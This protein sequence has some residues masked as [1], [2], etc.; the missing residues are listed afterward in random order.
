MFDFKINVWRALDVLFFFFLSIHLGYFQKSGVAFTAWLCD[1]DFV[2]V[3]CILPFS[4]WQSVCVWAWVRATGRIG[5]KLSVDLSQ[6]MIS[7]SLCLFPCCRHTMPFQTWRKIWKPSA[8]PSSANSRSLT[9]TSR[10]SSCGPHKFTLYAGF[11]Y[12]LVERGFIPVHV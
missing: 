5:L 8:A 3:S 12:V 2:S 1:S 11:S 10:H 7:P 6:P 9:F 4:C